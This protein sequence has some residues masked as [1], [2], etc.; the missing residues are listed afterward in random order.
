[1]QL[2]R[3]FSVCLLAGLFPLMAM[4]N[5]SSPPTGPVVLEVSGA[6]NVEGSNGVLA[7]D[8]AMLE[9]LEW[10]EIETYTSFTEGPQVFA[11]P[12]LSSLLT[13][14]GASG[15]V[16]HASAVNDYTVTIPVS[17]AEAHDVILAMNMN[18][19]PM[20]VRD[21]GPIWVVYPLSEEDAERRLFDDQMIWQLTRMRID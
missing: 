1:M 19:S 12:T 21:K 6:V 3:F 14:V 20:R 5:A 10:V 9:A 15:Q 17:D 11:G 7:F 4:A 16:I 8:R 2:W 18:G 13:A